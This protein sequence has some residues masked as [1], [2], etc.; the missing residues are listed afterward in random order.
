M[1]P[2]PARAPRASG[3]ETRSSAD[4]RTSDFDYD[5]PEGLIARHPAPRRDE[6]RLLAL[7]RDAGTLRDLRFRD[8][9]DLVPAGDALVLNDSRVF[10]ARLR[11]RKPTGAAAEILLLEPAGTPAA[12][13]GATDLRPSVPGEGARVWR[14][15]VRPGGK[16]K[17]GR[18]VEVGEG[19]EVSILDST[20]DGG[21]IV[22][23][24]GE[25]DP[26][27]LIERHGEVPLPPYLGREADPEDRD[28]YQTVYAER[29]GSVAAPTAG[30]HFTP[31]LLER[32]EGKG[33]EIVRLTLHVGI[34]TFRPVEAERPDAHE[35]H[36][37]R[38]TVTP[39]AAARLERVRA[40]G[41]AIWAVGTTSTRTLETVAGPD[42]AVRAGSGETDLFIRPPYRFRAVDRLVTNFHLPRS[43]LL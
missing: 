39:E 17:P 41:G 29:T 13:R 43:S 9:L 5:L 4:L 21:R 11:G 37:E 14:A 18:R 15:L 34:G 30:L 23:L 32:L 16:L 8:L 7:D 22:R 28:R 3:R 38:Y 25:E 35:L 6:S 40:S 20:P 19:L 36:S 26:W 10:P 1:A 33:V 42:G 12:S 31:E 27:T 24:E 2:G